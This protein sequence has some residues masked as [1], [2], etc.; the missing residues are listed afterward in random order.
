MDLKNRVVVF[1]LDL[2]VL[3][4]G[5]SDR[6]IYREVSR[7]PSTWR[8]AA[9]LVP[10]ALEANDI[11]SAAL[12]GSEELLEKVNIFDIYM[13]QG[14]PAGMKSLGLRFSYRS[15]N[16][17]LTDIEVSRVHSEIV[18]RIIALTGAKIRGEESQPSILN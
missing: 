3:A 7:F 15:D 4:A 16:R 6:I 17:T 5:F 9:F 2:D 18:Q 14:I 10:E 1:E 8:D 11:I 13:E 12:R